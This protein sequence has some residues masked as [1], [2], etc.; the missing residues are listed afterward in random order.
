MIPHSAR[1]FAAGAP[2]A[3]LLSVGP[4]FADIEVNQFENA[5]TAAGVDCVGRSWGSMWG[6]LNGDGHPDFWLVNHQ[7]LPHL[8]LN[9]GDGTFEEVRDEV[10]VSEIEGAYDAHGAAWADFDNDGDQDIYQ[11]ADEKDGPIA[12]LF[13]VNT[14]GFLEEQAVAYGLDCVPC[15]GRMP[16]WVDYDRDGILDVWHPVSRRGDSTDVTSAFYHQYPVGVFTDVADLVGLEPVGLKGDN[17]GLLADMTG[18]GTLELITHRLGTFPHKIFDMATVPFEDI[19]DQLGVPVSGYPS[20]DA[21]AADLDGD[22]DNDLYVARGEI[23]QEYVVVGDDEFQAHL[24]GFPQET[25]F[26]FESNGLVHFD[27]Y[28]RFG[29]TLDQIHVGP[30]G[31]SPQDYTFIRSPYDSINWGLYPHTPGVD[32]GIY[33]GYDTLAGHWEIVRSINYLNLVVW[34]SSAISNIT[35]I[36]WDPSTPPEDDLLY[37]NLGTTFEDQAGSRGMTEPSAARNV[38]A[39][40]F[41]NDMDLDL[42]MVSTG[43]AVNYANILYENVGGGTFQLVADAGGASGTLLGRGDAVTTADYDRDGFLDLLVTNGVSKAPFEEGGPTELFRNLGNGN[44]WIEFDL[45]GV[46]SNRDAVGCRVLATA[47]GATQLR[48][49]N[50]GFHYRGQNHQRIHFGLGGNTMVDDLEVRW[51]NGTIQNLHDIPA[52]QIVE[53]VEPISTGS[54]EPAEGA[55]A[56]DRLLGCRPNPFNP[57]TTVAFELARP[58]A[59]RLTVHDAAGRLVRT[60]A[61]GRLLP[62]GRSE[63]VWNGRDEAGAAAASGVYFVRLETAG[64]LDVSKIILLR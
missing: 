29:W 61:A 63:F 33:I 43:A 49:Q 45:V 40:D 50:G 53:V 13:F 6:D 32:T 51:P 39:A 46:Q 27:I 48:E 25:G 4:V 41:D 55:P 44:H 3:L 28:P 11:L 1:L 23:A 15:R 37:I 31:D 7:R 64:A 59:V 54:S 8:Y 52:D 36:N 26:S 56:V 16:V 12:D 42:Y 38:V 58:A 19:R 5:T 18:D 21:V 57:I 2:A 47:G 10:I 60:L 30:N 34:S 17:F 62:A 14:G 24:Q 22:L 20:I 35:T 9:Q